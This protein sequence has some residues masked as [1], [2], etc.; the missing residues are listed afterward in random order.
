MAASVGI[1]VVEDER[2]VAE[3]LRRTLETFGYAVL[4]IASSGEEAIRKVAET[5]PDL[6][7]MD[8]RLQGHMDGTEAAS[9]IRRQ[10]D[11]PVV[12][13]T[14]Y[15]DESTLERARVA[16]PYGYIIKPFQETELH[17]SIEIALYKHKMEGQ[18]KA[19]ERWLWAT[20]RCI[21]EA[22]IAADAKECVKFMNPIAEALTGRKQVVLG[23]HFQE[24]FNIVDEKTQESVKDPVGRLSQEGT[25]A[26]RSSGTLLIRADGSRIPIEGNAGYIRDDKGGLTGVVAVFRDVTERRRTEAA[27]ARADKLRALAQTA[28]G[29]AHEFNNVLV[30]IQGCAD[31]ALMGLG[32][33]PDAVREDM[34]GVISGAT[35]AAR[36]VR[37]LELLHRRAD[38]L[39]DFVPLQLDA[40]VS[41]ALAWIRSHWQHDPFAERGMVSECA[42]T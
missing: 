40:L 33:D 14:A 7:L 3:D 6:V 20:L 13:L 24:V 27:L 35:D 38:D 9:R 8:I 29:I 1:L 17:S 11:I 4:G 21:G 28:G 31:L 41:E 23:Q 15:G 22:V 37:R 2:I 25:G 30:R 10:F 34:E 26:N 12:Y 18:L 42:Q 36:V 19:S 39:S 5:H 16:E 32:E